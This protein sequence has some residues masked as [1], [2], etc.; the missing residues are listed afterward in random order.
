MPVVPRAGIFNRP[1]QTAII[2]LV[3][4]HDFSFAADPA[5]AFAWNQRRIFINGTGYD[6]VGLSDLNS[7][8]ELIR[9]AKVEIT[10]MPNANSLDYNNQTVSTGSTNI[11]Y[12]YTAIDYNDVSS[13]SLS[14]IKQ[15]PTVKMESFD[16]MIKRTVYPRV[17]NDSTDLVDVGVNS[18]NLFV[19]GT[20]T[21]DTMKWN[22]FVMVGDLYTVA[23][24]YGGGHI[25][26]KIYYECINSR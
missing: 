18:R 13:T 23:L 1:G 7:V 2:P 26:F 24:T 10:I 22:G 21:A 11:P 15:N 19:R 5:L 16:H 9:V 12:M 25:D 3:H 14:S 4:S 17:Q 20:S 8:W 6:V